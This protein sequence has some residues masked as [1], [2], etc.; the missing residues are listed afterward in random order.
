MSALAQGDEDKVVPPNQVGSC[1]APPI[2]AYAILNA[3]S[4]AVDRIEYRI[5]DE[6]R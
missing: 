1:H 3:S 2:H 6:M 5:I 4:A